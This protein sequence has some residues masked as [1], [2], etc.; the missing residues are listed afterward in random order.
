E[1]ITLSV[2]GVV[3]VQEEVTLGAGESKTLTF[4]VTKDEPGTYTIDVNGVSKTLTVKEEVKPTETATA[5]PTPTP[6]QPGFEAVFAIV[7]LLAVAYL[8][9]RQREE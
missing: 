1:T 7:G 5:T 2:N 9:L 3:T 8:V 6:T 4:E